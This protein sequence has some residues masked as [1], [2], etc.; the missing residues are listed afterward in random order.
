MA[1]GPDLHNQLA[2]LGFLVG[3]WSGEGE[4]LWGR[5]FRFGDS[6]S[7]SHDGRPF[8]EYR[9]STTDLA[10]GRPSHS[11]C[12]YFSVDASGEVHVTIAEPSGLTEILVGRVE[13][14]VLEVICTSIG[15]TP[16][17]KNVTAA[18]RRYSLDGSRLVSQLAIAME[19]EDLAPHTRSLLAP[20]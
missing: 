19:G 20:A 18:A 16:G 14:G 9:Q 11:E 8:L 4:G 2:P 3:D 13:D 10:T 6:V 15:R 7:F 17:S 12:G 5:A 1:S